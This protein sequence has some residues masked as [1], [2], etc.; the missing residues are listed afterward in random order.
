LGKRSPTS[1]RRAGRRVREQL[2][3]EA[4]QVV[5][6]NRG[7]FTRYAVGYLAA[8]S[9][10]VAF[11]VWLGYPRFAWFMGG[12]LI[13]FIPSLVTYFLIAQGLAHRQMGGDAETWTAEELEALDRR[14]WRVFHD[15]PVRYGNVDHVAVGPGR[16]YAIETKWTSAGARYVGSLAACARRQ[17]DRLSEE[18]S[19]RGA[20]RPVVPLLVVWGPGIGQELGDRPKMIE[21]VRVVAG[22]HASTWIEKMREA[23]DRLE[24]DHPAARAIE[25]V[26]RDEERAGGGRAT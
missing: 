18:L 6:R 5:R 20:G 15:V 7:F 8:T 19:R 16:V 2:R 23:A 3:A 24:I 4:R 22:P 11:Y 12:L 10:F 13:G 17:A 14:T 25:A 26:I 21:D 1:K 9:C